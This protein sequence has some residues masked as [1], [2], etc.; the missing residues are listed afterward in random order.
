M[1]AIS[2]RY[3]KPKGRP[4]KRRSL[5]ASKV[6]KRW[7]KNHMQS[8]S[9]STM[10]AKNSDILLAE[11]S[12]M[13]TEISIS[14]EGSH[15]GE[16]EQCLNASLSK[17]QMFPSTSTFCT[18]EKSTP[19]DDDRNCFDANKKLVEAFLK[20]GK[21]HA[22][23]ELSLWLLNALPQKRDLGENSAEYSIWYKSHQEECSENYVGSSNAMEVKAAEILWKRSIKNCGMRYVSILSDG[24]AKTYQHL[25]SLMCMK[26]AVREKLRMPTK[27][28]I[29]L[30]GKTAQKE[31]FVSKKRLE[32]GVISA[33]GGYNFGCFNS[34][35]IEH[36]E[37]SS[38]SVD[39]SHK[40]D[41]RCLAQSEK[42]F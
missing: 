4:S 42:E 17:L 2:R 22:A 34:L 12:F 27:A 16:K 32:M 24:D 41:K 15:A 25:S 1:D 3:R 40:R 23:L 13:D 39:I 30:F 37:L 26:D 21:G 18:S 11:N 35:A 9:D 31:T 6:Q 36:N 8:D 19:R 33:I 29:V 14:D 5:C 38:V 7:E 10:C 20:I 28:S